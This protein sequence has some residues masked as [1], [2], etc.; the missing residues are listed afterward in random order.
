MA[1]HEDRRSAPLPILDKILKSVRKDAAYIEMKSALTAAIA[2]YHKLTKLSNTSLNQNLE[3]NVKTLADEYRSA[4]GAYVRAGLV[5]KYAEL[6][7]AFQGMSYIKLEVLAQRKERLY[8]TDVIESGK[9]G[10]VKYIDRNDKQYFW[11][12]NGEFWADELGDYVFALRSE[13]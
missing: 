6:Y 12:F 8:Q 2:E 4:L 1:D 13:C 5:S 7:S 3:K 11:N 9:R 10:D